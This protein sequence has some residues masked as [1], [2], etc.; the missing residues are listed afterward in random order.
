MAMSNLKLLRKTLETL[1]LDYFILPN[2]DEFSNEYLPKSANRLEFITGFTGSNATI[3]IGQKKAAFFTDGRYTIQAATEV[4][5]KDY[6]I[7]N[8][9]DKSWAKWLLENSKNND[10]IGFD[11]KLHSLSAINYYQKILE[12]R[13]IVFL[14]E[15]PVDHI[16]SSRPKAPATK[17]FI[18]DLKYAGISAE[19]KI[20]IITKNFSKN[21]DALILNSPISICWLLNIRATDI[22]FTPIAL[23]H[24]I[25]YKNGKVD[26]FI[27]EKRL[28][29]KVKKHLKNVKIISPKDLE[30]NILLLKNKKIQLDPN[31]CNYWLAS[32]LQ[33][34][35]I[36]EAT[37]P[38]LIQKAC[39]NPT[40]IKGMIKAHEIDGA[41]VTK[42]LLWLKNEAKNIDEIK[43]TK[44]L[45]EFR[46]QNK[47]FFSPSFAT[48][49]GFASNGAIVHYHATKKTNKKIKGN[50]LYL[51]DSG[52][53]YFYG[54]TDIT[55]TISIG[56]PTSEQKHN[57]T[58]VLKGHIALATAE[59]SNKTTGSDLD[60]LARQ[61]LQ[62]EG[63]DYDH[64]TGHGVGCFLSVHEGPQN[65][66]KRKNEIYLKP[67]MI[68]SN[69]PGYYK[70]GEYG[71]RI[72]NLVLVEKAKKKGFLKFKTI[73]LAP[74]DLNLIDFKLLTEAEKSW[75][76]NYHQEIYKKLKLTKLEK[77]Q[78]KK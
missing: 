78:L 13:K 23:C 2:N 65:I 19:E 73:T 37:D 34:S 40:E 30:K 32:L 75:L 36:I 24:A 16:W 55:R 21:A 56:K 53:Q 5:N 27:D 38:C 60:I 57:F 39:K 62:K 71:I 22:D 9:A 20:K 70:T 18:H 48:I 77:S 59:F 7:H 76:I 66:S 25:I 49:S 63:K 3:I 72:E 47:E 4:N 41:A 31:Y 17:A 26:L 51:V 28:D 35:K 54:T 69:E 42:F 12:K 10:K 64:G 1:N 43:T 44:K 74:I 33:K 46:K 15:N 14:K 52:G 11:P 45:L 6:E 8:L 58:L 29:P 50:S 68:I 67:G 61:F